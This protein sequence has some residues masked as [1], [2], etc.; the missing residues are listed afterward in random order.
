[1]SA[2]AMKV[3]PPPM[4]TMEVTPASASPLAIPSSSPW[5]TPWESALTGGLLAGMTPTWPCLSNGH[6]PL[7][8]IG[9]DDRREG[10]G[11]E[12]R[13]L[14]RENLGRDPALAHGPMR[15]HRIAR[16]GTDGVDMRVGRPA[17]RVDRDLAALARIDPGR[18]EAEAVA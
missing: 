6:A 9:E 14:P 8:G 18:L 10:G 5:R 1:M 15:A 3:R 7:L 12:P 16:H 17:L 11:V 13:R 2:P 4:M